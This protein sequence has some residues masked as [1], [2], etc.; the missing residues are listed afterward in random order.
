MAETIEACVAQLDIKSGNILLIEFPDY[1]T[2]AKLQQ[3]RD[4]L[5]RAFELAGREAPVLLLEGG[6]KL[7][8]LSQ[9][10]SAASAL[11]ITGAIGTA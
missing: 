5:A 6:A 11:T 3:V 8:V 10:D 1:L 9:D 4:A 2:P 7:S